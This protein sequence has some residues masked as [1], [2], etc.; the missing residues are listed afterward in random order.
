VLSVERSLLPLRPILALASFGRMH[1]LAAELVT[2]NFGVVFVGKHEHL[3]LPGAG[4]ESPGACGKKMAPNWR[5]QI[6]ATQLL[7]C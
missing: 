2:E 6:G 5:C 3:S 1:Q 7:C 4:R